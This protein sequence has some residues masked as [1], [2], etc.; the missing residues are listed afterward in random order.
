MKTILFINVKKGELPR[1]SEILSNNGIVGCRL[2][3]CEDL[4]DLPRVLQSQEVHCICYDIVNPGFLSD[5]E[6]LRGVAQE[7]PRIV[8][9][10]KLGKKDLV[11]IINW[12]AVFCYLE[13][14][15]RDYDFTAAVTNALAYGKGIEEKYRKLHKL[16]IEQQV[17]K[18]NKIGIALSSEHNLEKLLEQIMSQALVLA[19]CDAGSIYFK[20]GDKLAFMVA[21]NNT[22][23]RRY[24]EGYEE[25]FFKRYKFTIAKNRISGYVAVT[26]E[27]LNI[28]DA[29]GVEGKEYTFTDDFDRRTNYLT[30]SMIVAPM[31]NVDNNILGVLQLINCL[32]DEGEIVPFDKHLENLILSLASQAAVCIRNARLIDEVK[33]A[34][35][36]T[37]IKLSTAAEFLGDDTSEHLRRMTYYSLIVAK[38][39]DLGDDEMETLRCAAPMHDIGKI[40]IPDSILFK[41]GRLTREEYDVMKNHTLYGAQIL[42]GSSSE[43]LKISRIVALNHHERWNGQGYPHGIKKEE[44]PVFGQ[45]VSIADVFDALTSK[46]V[47][48]EALDVDSALAEIFA[49]RDV[50]FGPH[51]V[52]AFMRGV[53]E[54]VAVL[55]NSQSEALRDELSLIENVIEAKL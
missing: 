40:G 9:G 35:L 54:I 16:Y 22:L 46:R 34:H 28:K 36:D 23:K 25:K 3:P 44:I 29:Y 47:Y 55:K 52:D 4:Q 11:D 31:K 1:L 30:K 48:K 45:I 5:L 20:E 41:P 7:I 26:G 42:E 17:E 24:G 2:L 10:G 21:Q 8:C 43:I 39:L 13:K 27:V 15:F 37:I 50:R 19:H 51:I 53:D 49:N 18:L 12:G 14:P 32:D 38:H 6:Y 33:R